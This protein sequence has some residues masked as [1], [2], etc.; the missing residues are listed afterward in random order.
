MYN[1]RAGWAAVLLFA[2]CC[3]VGASLAK[4]YAFRIE[5]IGLNGARCHMYVAV[6]LFIS[7]LLET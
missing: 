3:L 4:D 5:R 1:N 7:Q 6:P 2:L